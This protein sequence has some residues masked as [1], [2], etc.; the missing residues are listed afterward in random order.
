MEPSKT[1]ALRQGG[2]RGNQTCA[3]MESF[4]AQH[5]HWLMEALLEG[6]LSTHSNTTAG[7]Q[8]QLSSGLNSSLENAFQQEKVLHHHSFEER[9]ALDHN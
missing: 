2:R 6:C 4:M 5:M 7:M 9:F 3:R 1:D 8:N